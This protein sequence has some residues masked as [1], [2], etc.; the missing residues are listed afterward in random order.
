MQFSR[1]RIQNFRSILDA[2][3]PLSPFVCGV[4]QNNSGKSS[5]LM[6]LSLFV[7]GTKLS[8]SD[9]YDPEREIVIS[10]TFDHVDE[11]SLSLLA[12]EHRERIAGLVCAQSL[13]LVRRYDT[14]GT[15]R[16]RCKRLQPRD[17][18]FRTDFIAEVFKGKK[19]KQLLETATAEY[20][21]LTT[22]FEGSEKA[23]IGAYQAIVQAHAAT[24]PVEEM[25]LEECDL[26][27]GLPESVRAMLPEPVYIPAVMDAKDEVK[28]KEASS[29]GKIL[30]I[31]LDLINETEQI[32]TIT[33]AFDELHGL[34]NRRTLADGKVVD[35][36]IDE[37]KRIEASMT[38]F[39]REQFRD[40]DVEIEIPPPDMR[41][42][43][44]NAKI[45][46]NDGIRGEIETKGDGL[47][48]AVTF[49]LFR[50]FVDLR[51][52]QKAA[53]AEPRK[54]G[55][56][57]FL[58]EEPELYLHPRAQRILFQALAEISHDH[59]VVVS[60]HS[61]YFFSPTATGTFLR[62]HRVANG[63]VPQSPPITRVVPVDVAN[64]ISKRDA[65]QI[66]CYE[67]NNAAF[68]CDRVVL[69][70]G[71]SD[72]L[73][74]K[75]LARTLNADWDLDRH[76]VAVVRICG[77]GSFARYRTFFEAFGLRV[78][79]IAD[80]D[81]IIDQYEKLG[82]PPAAAE[83]RSRLISDIDAIIAT[84]PPDVL[85]KSEKLKDI[86]AKAT[87]R[88]KYEQCKT[89]VQQLA[90]GASATPELLAAFGALF[91]EEHNIR[92]RAVLGVHPKVLHAKERLLATLRCSGI[93]VLSQGA[94]E[95]YYPPDCEGGDKPSKALAACARIRTTDDVRAVSPEIADEAGQQCPEFDLIFGTIF[96]P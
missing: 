44:G 52:A 35:G 84:T 19:G 23:T 27:T 4:G 17:T 47:K 58:F 11:E 54:R 63:A 56:Y 93:C 16:L 49:A 48:R 40:V 76:N 71:D 9:F 64:D 13:T 15:S 65:F 51:Q 72:I 46:L 59:Q 95:E 55:R 85:I 50:T 10:V 68:F 80:L 83:G 32:Q 21:E 94:V 67:N 8:R 38:R 14:D 39:I 24:L 30:K 42:V 60:T 91:S 79:I 78:F 86:C 69:V 53:T 89:A 62:L 61:P 25:T 3:V 2:E 36:R 82:A 88:D 73:Y 66:I 70:E 1:L 31:L 29:F 34:L 33:K 18:R 81:V 37:V 74:L 45:F 90:A 75:H 12:E 96:G 57:L 22:A 7:S 43:F 26:P 41:T 92:R 6:S 87:F 5:L 20:P 77:K 28:T